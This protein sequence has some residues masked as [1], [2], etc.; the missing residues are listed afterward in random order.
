MPKKLKLELIVDDKGSVKLKQF[1]K[2]VDASMKKSQRSVEKLSG[3]F[4]KRLTPAI[5]AAGVAAA[6]LGAA[7]VVGMGKAI[8]AASNLEE[9]V[10]KFNVVFADHIKQAENMA[11]VLVGS[12][13][14]S[15]REAKQYL[16]SVQD[17]LVPMGMAS[18]QAVVMSN[19]VVKLAADLGSFNNLPTAQV[20]LDM[21]SALVG[22]FETMKKY[23]VVLNETVVKQEAQNMGLYNG[24]GLLDANIKAQVAYKLMVKGS[25]AAIGDQHRTMGSYANQMKQLMAN[26]EDL[27]A[28]I[29]NQL[30]PYAT[31]IVQ[32]TND[33]VK[34]ND[35]LIKQKV[36]E[37]AEDIATALKTI[38]GIYNS[39][40]PGIVGATGFG[41]LGTAL[42]G[43]AAGKTI[44]MLYLINTQMGSIGNS[45]GDLVDKHNAAKD[46]LVNLWD[47]VADAVKGAK[48]ELHLYKIEY[49]TL[50]ETPGFAEPVLDSVNLL[51]DKTKKEKPKYDTEM[52][53]SKWSLAV[54]E[55]PKEEQKYPEIF[56]PEG[57]DWF[58]R[59][60]ALLEAAETEA[61]AKLEIQKSFQEQYNESTMNQFDFERQKVLEMAE[62]YKKADVDKTKIAEITASR[63]KEIAR[64]EQNVKLN[65]Y[66][67]AAG[68]IANTFKSIAEAGG[69][70]SKK[71]FKMYK[72]F[73]MVEAAIN[74][75]QGVTKAFAQGG[76]LGFITGAAVAAAGAVQIGMI[77][78]SQPPS[79][80]S[81]GVSNAKGLYQ[82]G[83]IAEAHIPIPSGGKIPVNVNGG[84]GGSVKVILNNPVFQ[85]VATQRRVLT[86]IAEVVAR[87]VAPGAVVE[88][89]QNDGAVRSMIRSGA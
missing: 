38:I 21:Q 41:L 28:M 76:V 16:S 43:G 79:Y 34:A 59:S 62:V 47:S 64:E 33:W 67:N 22:N 36:K 58:E 10:G 39:L 18:D 72:A 68:G 20:M 23:G 42:L 37:T 1:D 81:G 48:E 70:Q 65:L 73:A 2:N 84:G 50:S 12:Y 85:D 5:T 46:A 3:T 77:A 35:K 9:T 17:L 56:E 24:K 82:T 19:E 80:D 69:E 71:A 86:Q 27:S 15:T 11:D 7:M 26:V 13:A 49:Q 60:N 31:K 14:M 51:P 55:E 61:D 29:G 40:P 8:K 75:F 83:D 74:V 54:P 6:A 63:M 32:A 44:A 89:Y 52:D 4:K 87:R 30:L 78:S 53:G 45:F 25:T 88:N 66:K 57:M